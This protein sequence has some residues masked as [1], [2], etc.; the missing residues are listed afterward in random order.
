[1][2]QQ[3]LLPQRLPLTVAPENRG[4]STNTDSKLV[5]A[6]LEQTEK[7]S[8]QICKR[9]GYAYLA[10]PGGGV[11]N[12]IGLGICN[13]EGHRYIVEVY[14]GSGSF[15]E[16]GTQITGVLN[17]SAFYVFNR[18]V[19]NPTVSLANALFLTNGAHSY[20]VR[21]GNLL[22]VNG[23]L[24]FPSNPIVPG[25]AFL[26]G[27][28]YVGTVDG[29]IYNSALNDPLTW[30][31]D[32]IV[33]QADAGNL[34]ALTKQLTYVVAFKQYSTEFFYDAANTVG[35][36]L[37]SVPA[38]KLAVGC[39][40]AYSIANTE[41]AVFWVS[42]TTVGGP[43]VMKMN[44]LTPQIISNPAV[45]RLLQGVLD[46]SQSVPH[47]WLLKINGHLFY[48]ISIR[49]QTTGV[50]SLCLVFDVTTGSW[51][52]WTSPDGTAYPIVAAAVQN[53]IHGVPNYTTGQIMAGAHLCYI[54]DYLFTDNGVP[55]PVDIVTP[56]YD[57]GTRRIKFLTSMEFISDQ[58]G[59]TNMQVRVSDDDYKT[60]TN[61]RTVDMSRSRPL[62]WDCGSFRRRAFHFRHVSSQ[63]F[64]IQAVDLQMIPGTL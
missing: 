4:I 20:V 42:N 3:E 35:S 9:P 57:G 28:L 52:Q 31:G 64:R 8:Y 36:P 39:W 19:G 6:Y 41:D 45:D 12:T 18:V 61:F 24:N 21:G 40:D 48:G 44:A 60:W 59:G 63:P 11:S 27:T 30:T 43:Q 51:A 47:G 26:D 62:L 54:T 53:D 33:A 23:V 56:G 46:G 14:A 7:D 5:N 22:T 10:D 13:W 1:M 38:S 32:T 49:H 58:N 25:G 50:V 55:F 15:Y 2:P 34:V 37:L 16:D 17:T 29:T